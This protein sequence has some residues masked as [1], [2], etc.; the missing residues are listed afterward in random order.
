MPTQSMP[1]RVFGDDSY[2][3]E[4]EAGNPKKFALTLFSSLTWHGTYDLGCGR[5]VFE[6]GSDVTDLDLRAVKLGYR[7]WKGA[8]FAAG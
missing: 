4:F 1:I 2:V 7:V 3:V 6:D 8:G 5:V